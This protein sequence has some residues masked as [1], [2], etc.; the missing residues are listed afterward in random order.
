[1]PCPHSTTMLGVQASCFLSAKGDL[2]NPIVL[3]STAAQ[4]QYVEQGYTSLSW[5]GE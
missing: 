4:K 3:S 1:M 2:L 5:A